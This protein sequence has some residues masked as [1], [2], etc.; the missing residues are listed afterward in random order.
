MALAGCVLL[1]EL[2]LV[3]RGL[4]RLLFLRRVHWWRLL[5]CGYRRI[6]GAY[7]VI[8][9]KDSLFLKLILR[10]TNCFGFLLLLLLKDL[11]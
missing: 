9:L 4:W 5:C 2:D 10:G 11:W 7:T 1:I 8:M 6:I 3:L